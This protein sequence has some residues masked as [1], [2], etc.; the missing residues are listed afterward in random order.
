M[1]GGGTAASFLP[2]WAGTPECWKRVVPLSTLD[3]LTGN[4]FEGL[5]LLIKIDVEGFEFEMLKGAERILTRNP[6]PTWIVEICL[7][8]HFRS[9]FN[10]RFKETFEMFWSKGYECRLAG[11][12]KRTVTLSDVKRWVAQGSVDFGTH[13]YLFIP[14][15]EKA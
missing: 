6:K 15:E 11:A 10:E 7:N 5:P 14:T 2:G 9:G 3:V 4:R 8:E 12:G 13:N 1:Y